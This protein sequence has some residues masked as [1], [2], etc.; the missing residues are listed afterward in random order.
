MEDTKTKERTALEQIEQHAHDI[1][2]ASLAIE[3]LTIGAS[4]GT[5]RHRVKMAVRSVMFHA[6]GILKG[7]KG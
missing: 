5:P 1:V 2:I 3:T 7:G 6:D 4:R